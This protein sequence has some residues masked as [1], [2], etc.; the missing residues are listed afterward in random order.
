MGAKWAAA[1][2]W[3]CACPTVALAAVLVTYQSMRVNRAGAVLAAANATASS[4]V[5]VLHSCPGFEAAPVVM[6]AVSFS[7]WAVNR[8]FATCDLGLLLT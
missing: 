5:A 8:I 3:L 2:A 6:I 7:H 4:V 1:A